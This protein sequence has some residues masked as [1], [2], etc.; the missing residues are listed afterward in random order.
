[1]VSILYNTKAV[2]FGISTQLSAVGGTPPYVWSIDPNPANPQGTISQTGFYIGSF[3]SGTDII[4]VTDA[5]NA[6]DTV[7][8]SVLKPLELFCDILK[9]YM[10]LAD[11]QVYIYNEKIA[12]I[13]DS[14]L[15]IA[16]GINQDKYF[17]STRTYIAD[18]NGLTEQ[19]SINIL[20]NLSI[21]IVSRGDEARYRRSEIVLALNSKYSQNQ[22]ELNS[23]FIGV[24]PVG[25][26]NLSQQEGAAI[27]FRFN[28]TVNI[29][30][31]EFVNKP[32]AFFD[33]YQSLDLKVNP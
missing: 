24:L 16:V 1:M 13:T 10:G 9:T 31:F 25:F 6:T 8:I 23:F 5:T 20:S 4:T 14:R 17:G 28:I 29:Q 21:D 30:Y 7:Q 18:A 12:P 27:P 19:Q 32:A 26:N 11:D 2:G 33:V 15:Y 3:K 22:Q